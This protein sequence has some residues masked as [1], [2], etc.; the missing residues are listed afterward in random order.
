M[1]NKKICVKVLHYKGG[2]RKEG[3]DGEIEF[4]I[5][6][7]PDIMKTFITEK[8]DLSV[9]DWAEQIAFS[10]DLE[11]NRCFELEYFK[12]GK[13]QNIGEVYIT[14]S[15]KI[16]TGSISTG[17]DK[18]EVEGQCLHITLKSKCTTFYKIFPHLVGQYVEIKINESQRRIEEQIEE[19]E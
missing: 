14:K 9:L 8:A 13:S 11:K 16:R 18:K 3:V 1:I 7:T 5:R 2:E 15:M 17:L 4:K 10:W 6:C 19:K 12:D